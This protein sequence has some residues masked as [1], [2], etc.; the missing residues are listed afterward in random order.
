[1]VTSFDAYHNRSSAEFTMSR[2]HEDYLPSSS[3]SEPKF[4]RKDGTPL[5][6]APD[7]SSTFAL[8]DPS[9]GLLGE[10][11]DPVVSDVEGVA[12]LGTP[13]DEE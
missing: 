3:S 7:I 13:E 12:R 10:E 9:G 4:M 2:P 5:L 8:Y 11:I 6:T 1:M